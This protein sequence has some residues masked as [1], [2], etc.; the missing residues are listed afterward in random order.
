MNSLANGTFRTTVEIWVLNAGT[1][2]LG[3]IAYI[4]C[5]AL[6][7]WIALGWWGLTRETLGQIALILYWVI[8]GSISCAIA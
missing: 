3:C 4:T 6:I 1:I 8:D 2:P 5:I 7:A